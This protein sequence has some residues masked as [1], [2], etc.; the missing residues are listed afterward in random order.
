[1]YDVFIALLRVFYRKTT[2][3]FDN[4]QL[5]LKVFLINSH[6]IDHNSQFLSLAGLWVPSPPKGSGG[7][8]LSFSRFIFHFL[9][10]S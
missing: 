2:I 7:S 3:Y 1:M 6:F 8:H 4:V 9:G 10:E 5:S